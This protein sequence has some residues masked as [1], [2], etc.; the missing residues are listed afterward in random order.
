M[1]SKSP[2][3]TDTPTEFPT[4]IQTAFPSEYPMIMLTVNPSQSPSTVLTQYPS[5]V[6]IT[7]G[8][9]MD[10]E[11]STSIFTTEIVKV[12]STE[13]VLSSTEQEGEECPLLDAA[14]I[15]FYY[16]GVLDRKCNFCLYEI[17]KRAERR[18]EI[19][20][21]FADNVVDT[22][23]QCLLN[24]CGYDCTLGQLEIND[25]S[26]GVNECNCDTLQCSVL[27]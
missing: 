13:I 3:S 5:E 22:F 10:D 12:E 16:F 23:S 21:S 8:T 26:E 24:V 6:P 18:C 15:Y 20:E 2:I 25:E 27:Q 19:I 1:P 4:V 17:G 14:I 9:T 11:I 7:M